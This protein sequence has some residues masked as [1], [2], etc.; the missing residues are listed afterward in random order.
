KTSV[1]RGLA[2]RASI[3]PRG[4]DVSINLTPSFPAVP[5][6]PVSI[7]VLG[8]AFS[9]VASRTLTLEGAAVALDSRGHA[10]FTPSA[11]GRYHLA[12]TATDL[13]GYATTTTAV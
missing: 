13:D 11:T 4:P 1:S 6:Q 12:T 5:G 2:L 7:T 8:D 9:A 3:A 10:T